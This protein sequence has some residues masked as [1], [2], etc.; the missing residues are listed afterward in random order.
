MA[1]S[2]YAAIYLISSEK[3]NPDFSF[4]LWTRQNQGL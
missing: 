4:P 2:G 3:I 1:G